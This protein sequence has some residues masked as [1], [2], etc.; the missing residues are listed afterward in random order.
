MPG[1]V[2]MPAAPAS[3]ACRGVVIVHPYLLHNCARLPASGLLA[4]LRLSRAQAVAPHAKAKM[5][6]LTDLAVA[7]NVTA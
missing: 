3:P 6:S 7:A 1:K 2:K 5:G 4:R